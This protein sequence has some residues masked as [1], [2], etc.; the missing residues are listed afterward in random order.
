LIGYWQGPLAQD[1]Y[2]DVRDFIDVGVAAERRAELS[3]YLRSGTTFVA[4]AGF[5]VCR[6]CGVDNGS[7]ELTDGENFVWP[8]GLAHYVEMHDVW[9]PDDV[10]A[11]AG[12][13][14]ARPVDLLMFE[15]AL[16]ETGELVVDDQWWR[17]L[18]R[19]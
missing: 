11:A 1:G 9:L 5:S 10:A 4:S 17:T 12:R 3:T 19:S 18:R 2:P 14:P 13:G 8:Q 7:T 15:Q 6:I 16:I